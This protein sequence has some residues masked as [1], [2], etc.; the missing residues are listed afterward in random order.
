MG[1]I[2]NYTELAEAP[3]DDDLFVMVDVSDT[4]MSG[5]GTTKHVKKSNLGGGGNPYGAQTIVPDDYTSVGEAIAA[6]T[7][8]DTIFVRNG[9]HDEIASRTVTQGRVN[10]IG[11]SHLA[12]IKFGNYSWSF[13]NYKRFNISNLYLNF[14]G[15]GSITDGGVTYDGSSITN[16]YITISGT[17]TS[18]INLN[19]RACRF[20]GNHLWIGGLLNGPMITV[21]GQSNQV[22]DNIFDFYQPKSASTVVQVSGE[23]NSVNNNIFRG[24]Y[25]RT[26]SFAVS[27]SGTNNSIVGNVIEGVC[28]GIQVNG[29]YNTVSSNNVNIPASATGI[30][31]TKG[32]NT[33]TGNM[34]RGYQGNYGILIGSYDVTVTGNTVYSGDTAT[35][36]GIAV[37]LAGDTNNVITGNRSSGW[38]HGVNIVAAAT[39]IVVTGN[40]LKSNGTSLTDNGSGTINSGNA[41]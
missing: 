24:D 32:R 35:G 14:S 23:N 15:T 12:V 11:E 30:E 25:V 18:P 16:C 31:I 38:L 19:K 40:N 37:E 9:T 39:D 8:G 21:G 5:T 41:T 2:T 20:M 3:A 4:T 34:V 22:T 26:N 17:N 13:S 10:I 27:L 36:S 29:F 1:K 6:S 33:V 28:S 7:S